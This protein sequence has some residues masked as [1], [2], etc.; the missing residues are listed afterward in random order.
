MIRLIHEGLLLGTT[1]VD[2]EI[3][4]DRPSHGPLRDFQFPYFQE[5]HHHRVTKAE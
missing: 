5:L 3:I 4:W 2:S 1:L